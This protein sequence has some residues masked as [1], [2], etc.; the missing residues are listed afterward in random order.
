MNV[1]GKVGQRMC[2]DFLLKKMGGLGGHH[3]QHCCVE[4][5]VSSTGAWSLPRKQSAEAAL[6]LRDPR[7]RMWLCLLATQERLQTLSICSGLLYS[8]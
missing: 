2:K 3:S 7:L 1:E 5:N 8:W 6:L 4:V